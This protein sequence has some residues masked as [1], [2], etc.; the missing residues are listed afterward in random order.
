MGGGIRREPDNEDTV[1]RYREVKTIFQHAG[2]MDYFDKTKEGDVVIAMEFTHTYDNE[3]VEVRG[4]KVQADEL[5]IAR[6][7]GLPRIGERW[8][9]R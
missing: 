2:W 3:I 4:L 1:Y 7:F 6:V 8:F 5:T 9:E